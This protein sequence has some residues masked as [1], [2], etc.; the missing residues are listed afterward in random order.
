MIVLDS[1]ALVALL[2]REPGHEMV[3]GRLAEAAV[4]AV[5]ISEVLARM[6]RENISPRALLPRLLQLGTSIVAFD[7]AQA[8][9]ASEIRERA[10]G[11]GMGLADCC[12]LALAIH[13]GTPVMTADRAWNGLEVDLQ[14]VMIR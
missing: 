6:S 12:C 9:I 7:A 5:N 3:A 1:S 14:I 4:S 10:R 8:V 13:R 11:L 2:L